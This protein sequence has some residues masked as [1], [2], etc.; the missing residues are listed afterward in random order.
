M[1]PLT[2]REIGRKLQKEIPFIVRSNAEREAVLKGA[3]YFGVEI[4]TRKQK[5]A[6]G[7]MVY[8]PN[9]K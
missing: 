6:A 9:Q 7:F 3:P 8:F 5:G 4:F 2:K 1:K